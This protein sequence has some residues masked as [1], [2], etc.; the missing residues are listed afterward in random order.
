M[1]KT[2]FITGSSGL[3]AQSIIKEIKNSD[4]FEI[5]DTN[6]LQKYKN[7][8]HYH[9]NKKIKKNEV[10]ITDEKVLNKIYNKLSKKE[11]IVIH[12]A[13][14]VNTDKCENYSYE[15]VKSNVYGT[16][17]IIDLCKKLNCFLF[18]FSTTAVFD[19]DYYMKYKGVFNE[20]CKISPKTIY[21]LTKYIGELA[22]KQTLDVNKYAVI[23]PVF[24]YGDAPQDNSSM[25]RKILEKIILGD[26]KSKLQV[27]LNLNYK[28]DYMRVEFFANMFTV[29]LKNLSLVKGRDFIISRNAP[30][31]FE[32]Y[33]RI[34]EKIT[35]CNHILDYIQLN[36]K[37]DYLK[38][39][40]GISSNF[41]SLFPNYQLAA[42]AFDNHI[43]IEKTYK[44]I[45]KV[46]K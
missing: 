1:K 22:V 37:K 23:K 8:F 20:T 41:Y 17:L 16:Q 12:T 29:L 45:K 19:P 31:Y 21:G 46:L 9:N 39:H 11:C 33:L 13:A 40:N 28:K 25:I 18:Y 34:I 15:A 26:K 5:L 6:N 7:D 32:Y 35:N 42:E 38:N 27:D 10:D 44:S 36:P 30:K 14:F 24:I 2:I 43:G 4:E 3:L